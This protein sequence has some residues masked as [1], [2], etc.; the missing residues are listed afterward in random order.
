M[1]PKVL[2]TAIS[3]FS[4][5]ADRVSHTAQTSLATVSRQ[6]F[7]RRGKRIGYVPHASKQ[8]HQPTIPERE[9][10]N[11]GRRAQTPRAHVD[12]AQHEGRQR[13]GAQSKRGG[14]GDLAVLDLPVGTRLELTTEGGETLAAA[15]GVDVGERTVAEAGGG[16]GGLVLLVGHVAG[17]VVPTGAAVEAL[18]LVEAIVAVDAVPRVDGV[19][20][21]VRHHGTVGEYDGLGQ[22]Q[23][24]VGV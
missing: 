16:C 8:L 17:E 5:S 7:W 19:G 3:L 1:A 9:A 15:G 2:P 20:L 24:E 10:H 4:A 14:V 13:E 22:G 6:G 11:Q 21:D 18:L 12:Q 23:S